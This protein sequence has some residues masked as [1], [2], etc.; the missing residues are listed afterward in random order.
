[1]CCFVQPAQGG[2]AVSVLHTSARDAGQCTDGEAAQAVHS[3]ESGPG[4]AAT[5]AN[6]RPQARNGTP[7]RQ[8]A[9]TSESPG[10]GPTGVG[11]PAA[12][13]PTGD[14]RRGP[15][16]GAQADGCRAP[17]SHPDG[18]SGPVPQDQTSLPASPSVDTYLPPTAAAV[19]APKPVPE[20]CLIVH[21]EVCIAT[22]P[23]SQ[24]LGFVIGGERLKEL[25]FTAL[26]TAKRPGLWWRLADLPA[27]CDA[28]I[29]RL[30][31]VK[32]AL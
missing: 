25:G 32:E 27:I 2:H 26:T 22:G 16:T 14:Q 13:G 15:A 1:M 31:A 9:G 30:Q 17:E 29:A 28:L 12:A 24:R 20:D 18:C 23:L 5:P 7:C 11:Q 8:D 3:G 21:G 19:P 10:G 6:V 4:A